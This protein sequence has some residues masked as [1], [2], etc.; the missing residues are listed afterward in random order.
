VHRPPYLVVGA[1]LA[2]AEGLVLLGYA[3][4]EV[5]NA[6]SGRLGP[7]VSTALFFAVLGTALVVCARG[8]W[9]LDS[10]ARSPVVVV[11]LI[12]LLTSWSFVGGRTT[13]VAVV[14]AAV[15]LSTLFCLFHPRSIEA[16]ASDG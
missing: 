3:V 10:W 4:L 2:L 6:A 7:A 14:L 13:P 11:Q 8:L 5:V 15:S 1:A 12:V 9:R 16:L